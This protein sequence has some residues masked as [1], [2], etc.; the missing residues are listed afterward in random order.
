[1]LD[2]L[3]VRWLTYED[4]EADDII[5]TLATRAEERATRR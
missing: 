1:M 5:A 2:A 4:Y 3:G